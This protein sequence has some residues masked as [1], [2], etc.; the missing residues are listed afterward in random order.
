MSTT[1]TIPEQ[2]A[3]VIII[4]PTIPEDREVAN[5]VMQRGHHHA[6]DLQ[7]NGTTRRLTVAAVEVVP[8]PEGWGQD[9]TPAGAPKIFP[10]RKP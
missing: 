2:G 7:R 10:Y 4:D 6:V 1:D 5:Y 3:L 9:K 8:T